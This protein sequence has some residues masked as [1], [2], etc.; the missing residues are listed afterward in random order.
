[1]HVA[2]SEGAAFGLAMSNRTGL[3]ARDGFSP[4]GCVVGVET[5]DMRAWRLSLPEALSAGANHRRGCC[6]DTPTASETH[7]WRRSR[8]AA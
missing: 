4:R 5:V 7:R 2:G 3:K 6:H 1:M 8:A